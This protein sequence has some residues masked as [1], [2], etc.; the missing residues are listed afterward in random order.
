MNVPQECMN[1][2]QVW[3]FLTKKQSYGVLSLQGST[4]VT[5]DGRGF[6]NQIPRLHPRPAFLSIFD[7][8]GVTRSD[9]LPRWRRSAPPTLGFKNALQKPMSDITDTTSMCFFFLQ[10]MMT[11]DIYI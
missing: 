7:Y 9:V 1:V 8:P 2:P 3:S 5:I 10:S 11:T 4:A 6:S